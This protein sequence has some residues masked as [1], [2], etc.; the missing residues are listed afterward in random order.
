MELAGRTRFVS[1]D[2]QTT[3]LLGMNQ[4]DESVIRQLQ[5]SKAI[6]AEMA[7]CLPLLLPRN[8]ILIAIQVET[9]LIYQTLI[10]N[11]SNLKPYIK[12][13]SPYSWHDISDKAKYESI[14]RLSSSTN[15]RTRP[16]WERGRASP[17]SDNLLAKW[18]LFRRFRLAGTSR[19]RSF[20]EAHPENL[21][22]MFVARP[23]SRMRNRSGISPLDEN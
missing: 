1:Q 13:M 6:F 21:D 4:A 10:V 19:Q 9:E 11:P 15:P 18:F 2:P 20:G 23:A 16:Y 22:L 14:I 7:V 3:L 8:I 17:S 12:K 5:M